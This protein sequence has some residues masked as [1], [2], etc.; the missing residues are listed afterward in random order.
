MS[1]SNLNGGSRAPARQPVCPS[2][3]AAGQRNRT[4]V[5]K[6]KA[7]ALT[8]RCRHCGKS[9]CRRE[10]RLRGAS[11]QGSTETRPRVG[12]QPLELVL[13]QTTTENLLQH[14]V[15][16]GRGSDL[17]SRCVNSPWW[18]GPHTLY[19]R[20]ASRSSTWQGSLYTTI[21]NERLKRPLGN[22]NLKA[23]CKTRMFHSQVQAKYITKVFYSI[24]L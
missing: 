4:C 2:T 15:P 10:G 13:A 9:V 22:N 1:V 19:R 20:A 12:S 7:N 11:G 23:P 6:T 17:P 21:S 8:M 14:I 18:Q 24:H 5:V 16:G 3:E